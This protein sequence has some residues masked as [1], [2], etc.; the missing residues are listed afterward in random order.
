MT[1]IFGGLSVLSPSSQ[2]SDED[3]VA[4]DVEPEYY[5]DDFLKTLGVSPIRVVFGLKGIFT[6]QGKSLK[7]CTVTSIEWYKNSSIDPYVILKPEVKEF[8][9]RR[10]QHFVVYI[11]TKCK[12]YKISLFLNEMRDHINLNVNALRIFGHEL[13]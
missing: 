4:M 11:W 10:F 13:C 5:S 7:P 9:Q 1:I 12:P 8:M 3:M 2:P 6:R